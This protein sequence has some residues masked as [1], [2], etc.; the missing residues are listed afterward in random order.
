M[1]DE[2]HRTIFEY[3][4]TAGGDVLV[5]CTRDLPALMEFARPLR[6][7]YVIEERFAGTEGWVP[8]G[9]LTDGS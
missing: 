7:P 4:L 1:T 9:T 2:D 5:H 6:R 3:R 8:Y